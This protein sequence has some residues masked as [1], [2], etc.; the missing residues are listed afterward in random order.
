MF[1]L[2]GRFIIMCIGVYA[3]R[4]S[5]EWPWW[6]DVLSIALGILTIQ[7]AHRDELKSDGRLI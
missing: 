4:L 3:I 6:A 7:A 2:I 5:S 1:R